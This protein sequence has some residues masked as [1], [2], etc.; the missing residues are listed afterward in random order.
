MAICISQ[1]SL[2]PTS[3]LLSAVGFPDFGSF[4]LLMFI[5]LQRDM[6]YNLCRQSGSLAVETNLLHA[7]TSASF[8]VAED[9]S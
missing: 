3:Q 9:R 5:T 4:Q 6:I 8:Q 7:A 1:K 2:H